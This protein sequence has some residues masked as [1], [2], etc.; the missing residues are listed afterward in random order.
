[1]SRVRARLE[2]FPTLRLA[3]NAYHGAGL[4]DCIRA[5]RTAA[6]ELLKAV[7]SES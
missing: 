2:A 3:G 7:N 6:Q 1:M 4:P 5:G